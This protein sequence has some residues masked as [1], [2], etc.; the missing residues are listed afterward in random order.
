MEVQNIF[1]AAPV[2]VKF[3]MGSG[4]CFYLPAYQRPYTW[5]ESDIRRLM[6]D[7]HHGFGKLI[8]DKM[9]FSFIGTLI[10]IVDTEYKTILPQLKTE[11]PDKVYL[12][13]DGQQRLTSFLI[14]FGAYYSLIDNSV[15]VSFHEDFKSWSTLQINELKGQINKSLVVVRDNGVEPF[16][17][18]P[19]MIRAHEDTWSWNRGTAEYQ[20]SI[21]KYLFEFARSMS[22]KKEFTPGLENDQK[23]IENFLSFKK[24]LTMM[25]S[26]ESDD[27]NL[28]AVDIDRLLSTEAAPMRLELLRNDLSPELKELIR[29]N[30]KMSDVFRLI[31]LGQFMF[32]RVGFTHVT[33][34]SESYAFDMF[35]SLNTTGEPLT[36]FETFKPRVVEHEGI[37]NYASSNSKKYIDHVES[38]FTVYMKPEEK[39]KATSDLLIPF[40]LL[41]AGAKLSSRISDQR[42]FLR[43][44]Y[45]EL[46][47][48]ELRVAFLR[49]LSTFA[50]FEKNVSQSNSSDI[51]LP[52]A[53]TTRKT[54]ELKVLIKCLNDNN[55]ISLPLIFRFYYRYLQTRSNEH[56]IEFESCVKACAAFFILWRSSRQT[57]AGIDKVYRELME[58]IKDKMAGYCID[59]TSDSDLSVSIIKTFF[60]SKLKDS[61]IRIES[62]ED[63][64]SRLN[65]NPLYI[66]NKDLTR[67]LLILGNYDTVGEN[68]GTVMISQSGYNDIFN[69]NFWD[70]R[71]TIEHVAPQK[72]KDASWSEE[73]FKDQLQETL[74]NL[75]LLPGRENSTL[76][77][78]SW[79]EKRSLYI[80]LTKPELTELK[81]AL[82]EIGVKE[83]LILKLVDRSYLKHLESIS[84]VDV[85]DKNLIQERSSNLGNIIWDRIRPWLN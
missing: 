13:I 66:V 5:G 81:E 42:T 3:L 37:E 62:K 53:L 59:N 22:E 78:R 68:Q 47:T 73:I 31:M 7:I 76:S 60:L 77:N 74:G 19:K 10:T 63:W 57:T 61:R 41:E 14:L 33:P 75:T 84:I 2:N 54:E 80:S 26:N 56:L 9:A 34:Q 23:I 44:R 70:L 28:E 83:N 65:I 52:L 4:V 36:A 46:T 69:S 51:L 38:M 21:A 67:L 29:G 49:R 64:V 30:K 35:E 6:G 40:A 16:N 15:D 82:K 79:E 32:A 45:S 39:Q 85:W 18:Y 1:L 20:S 55:E 43:E 12:V 27:D 48:N 25:S 58:G 72:P 50:D 11:L 24:L 71:L 17:R 8:N